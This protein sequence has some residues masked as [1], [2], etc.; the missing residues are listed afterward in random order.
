MI[1]KVRFE[2]LKFLIAVPLKMMGIK[3]FVALILKR[4]NFLKSP[5]PLPSSVMSRAIESIDF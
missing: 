3:H 2:K 1:K 5:H 4:M